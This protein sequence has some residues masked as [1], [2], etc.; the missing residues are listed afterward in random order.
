MKYN[1]DD[2]FKKMKNECPKLK[3]LFDDYRRRLDELKTEQEEP[4]TDNTEHYM[5]I[6]HLTKKSYYTITWNIETLKKVAQRNFPE[7]P[8]MNFYLPNLSKCVKKSGI[9]EKRIPVA[10]N[11]MEPII[12]GYM[13]GIQDIPFI[14]IDGNHRVISKHSKGQE[15]FHGYLLKPEM[16]VEAMATNLDKLLYKIHHNINKHLAHLRGSKLVEN[17]NDSG[18]LEI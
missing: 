14:I 1:L 12:V 13:S 18:I 10:L 9:E 4:L 11:N 8:N 2:F 3:S 6:I 7:K 5:Q 15:Y 16:H 17:E